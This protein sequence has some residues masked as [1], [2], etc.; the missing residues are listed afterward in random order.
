MELSYP[1]NL[2]TTLRR[3]ERWR[4]WSPSWLDSTMDSN[5]KDWPSFIA[6][7]RGNVRDARNLN[8]EKLNDRDQ[9]GQSEEVPGWT[10]IFI[11][12]ALLTPLVVWFLVSVYAQTTNATFHAGMLAL[13]GAVLAGCA[14]YFHE[15]PDGFPGDFANRLLF[16][17]MGLKGF[18]AFWCFMGILIAIIG[19]IFLIRSI[20]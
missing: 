18:R 19:V 4:D 13:F 1:G 3:R 16:E 9:L 10:R 17:G 6:D 2:K 15:P 5:P 8:R 12:V 14:P 11:L 7:S 20:Q